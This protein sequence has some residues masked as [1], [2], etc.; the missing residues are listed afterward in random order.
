[1][2]ISSIDHARAVRESVD[3]TRTQWQIMRKRA[4]AKIELIRILRTLRRK[5]IPFVLTGAHAIGGWTGEPR[6]TKDVDILVKGGQHHSRAVHAIRELYPHLEARD[7]AGVT[8]F[9]LPGE[10][11]SVIDITYPD[12]A[13]IE[14][15]LGTR[16]WVQDRG[17]RYRIPY[18]EAALANKYGAMLTPTRQLVKRQQDAV[19][20]MKMVLHSEEEGQP[21]I[22]MDKLRKLGEK[23]WRGGGGRE[24][25]RLVVHIKQGG[26]VDPNALMK[27]LQH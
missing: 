16:V 24:I 13:D 26:S 18:L 14:E 1:M 15:T 19:D 20:F 11:K 9:F 17:V 5:R 6:A 22:D 25:V 2:V 23:V 10:S 7:F 3:I 12:R 4:P 27:G 8:A 21:P